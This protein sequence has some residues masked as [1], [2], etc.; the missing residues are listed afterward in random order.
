M[1]KHFGILILIIYLFLPGIKSNAQNQ[2]AAIITKMENSLFG[3][4]YS[5]QNDDT[6]L[7]RLE[8]AV[9]GTISTDSISQRVTKLSKD[10]SA[11]VMGQE[12]KAK[13]DTFEQEQ[14]SYKEVIPKADSSVNYP[15]VNNLEQQV[16]NKE[17]KNE[18]INKRLANLENNV[19]KKNYSDDLNSRVERLKSALIPDRLASN[20]QDNNNFYPQDDIESLSPPYSNDNNNFYTPTIPQYN[21]NNSVLDPYNS[22]PDITIPLAQ[23]EKAT[24]KKSFPNDTASNRLTRMELKIFNSAFTDDGEQDRLDRI[25][26][27]HQ[28]QKSA[29]RYDSNKFAQHMSTAMQIG[30]ILLVVLAAVL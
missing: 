27:A 12:I 19:F 15:I 10:L 1:L 28:A 13:R 23:L 26:S 25:A 6:R 29:K 18:D 17:F 16:F 8:D 14:D 20:S 7:K 24:L 11:D 22:N 3:I 4:E 5:T 21:Y 2:Y 9:Y 30:A